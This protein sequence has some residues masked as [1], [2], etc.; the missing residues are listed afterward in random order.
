[1]KNKNAKIKLKVN[2]MKNLKLFT[3][4]KSDFTIYRFNGQNMHAHF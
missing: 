4:S 2:L 3:K 1:M